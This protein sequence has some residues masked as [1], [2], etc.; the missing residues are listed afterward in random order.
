MTGRWRQI[1]QEIFRVDRVLHE[2][3]INNSQLRDSISTVGSLDTRSPVSMIHTP[4]SSPASSVVLSSPAGGTATSSAPYRQRPGSAAGQYAK[5]SQGALRY[6]NTPPSSVTGGGPRMKLPPPT[7]NGSG[8]LFSPTSSRGASPSPNAQR[9]IYYTPPASARRPSATSIRSSSSLDNRPRW[10]ISVNTNDLDA[11]QNFKPL[12]A[13]TPIDHRKSPAAIRNQPGTKTRIPLPS[14]LKYGQS[15][16][17]NPTPI[18]TLMPPPPPHPNFNPVI[19]PTYKYSLPAGNKRNSMYGASG[20]L[21]SPLQSPRSASTYNNGG[22]DVPPRPEL[23][24]QHSTSRLSTLY[25]TGGSTRRTSIGSSNNGDDQQSA[26]TTSAVRQVRPASAMAG[27]RRM[28]MLPRPKSPPPLGYSMPG[29]TESLPSGRASR[30][31][32]YSMPPKPGQDNKP[33][34]RVI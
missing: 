17:R 34:W 2:L 7:R 27:G 10:N 19:H 4:D 9:T 25:K 8:S 31:K 3:H 14:P 32:R 23:R 16:S 15:P 21:K 29:G 30:A 26:A 6:N 24:S 28:S 20:F 12:S 33:R 13:T 22:L 11:P 18:P 1:E 5:V